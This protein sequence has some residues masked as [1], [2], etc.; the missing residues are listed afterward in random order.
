MDPDR[1]GS[2]NQNLIQERDPEMN[3]GQQNQKCFLIAMLNFLLSLTQYR[4]SISQ[5]S[6]KMKFLNKEWRYA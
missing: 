6:K 4:F 2:L 3:S 1:Y 5:I